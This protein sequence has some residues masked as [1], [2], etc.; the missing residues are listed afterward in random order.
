M[1]SCGVSGCLLTNGVRSRPCLHGHDRASEETKG[2]IPFI[3]VDLFAGA[4]GSLAGFNFFY[5]DI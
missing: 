4:G 5:M 1:A 3:V 2:L